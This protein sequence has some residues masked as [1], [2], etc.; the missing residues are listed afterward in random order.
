MKNQINVSKDIKRAV[1]I[2][3]PVV[4]EQRN[5]KPLI[6]RIFT[7]FSSTDIIFE[8]IIIDDHSTD[9]TSEVVNSLKKKYQ[10]RYFLKKGNKGKAYSLLEGFS[11]A[12]FNLLAMI[13]ADLQYPPEAIP[14]MV[15]KIN[16]EIGVVVAKRNHAKSNFTRKLLSFGFFY[17]FVK[18]LHGLD[19][20][21]QSGLKVFKKEII[22]RITLNPGPWSFDLEF[23]IKAKHAGYKI[24]DHNIFFDKRQ[25]EKPKISLIPAT[26]EIGLSALR[27]KF[28]EHEPI[29]FHPHDKK[30]KQEGFHYKGVPFVPH[31]NVS[32]HESALKTLHVNQKLVFLNLLLLVIVGL[33]YNWLVTS[34]VLIGVV[35]FI[36]FADL[37]FNLFLILRNFSK[38]PELNISNDEI[39]KLKNSDLPVYTILCPLYHEWEVLP[40]FVTA[41]SRLDYPK[42]KLQVMLLLEEDD[43]ETV[44]QAKSHKLP[45]YFKIVVV[46]HSLP[47]TKPKALNYGLT[48]AKGD[49]IVVYDAEDVPDPKQLKKV[50]AAF[51]KT[52]DKT[53]CIQA[54]L[55]FYNPHH[56]ILTR[57]FTA[58]YSLW[59]DLV[60][61]GLQSIFAPIPLGGTSNHFKI[62]D[63][64]KLK[65]WDSF[66]VTEDCD[67]G[68]RLVKHGYR[69]ALINS[70]TLEEANSD[71]RN[72]FQQRTRWIKG[73]LQTYLVHMRN[74]RD[75][76]RS[77]SKF[78]LFTFQLIV[79]GKILSMFINPLMWV[80]TIAYFAFRPIA[81]P[82]IQQFFPAPIL[83][84]GVFSLVF[85]NFL[86]MYYYMIGCVKRGH[87]D[88]V[89][90]V[91]LVPFYWLCM[92]IA[93]WKAVTQLIQN[94]HFWPKTIHG[95]HIDREKALLQSPEY[96]RKL[97]QKS[98][99]SF[100]VIKVNGLLHALFGR[101]NFAIRNITDF[102]DAFRFK[103]NVQVNQRPEKSIL[104]L[105]WRDTKHKF[106]GGAEVYIHEL[107]KRWV[108][109]G[110]KVTL[111][112]GNDGNCKRYEII[113]GVEIIRRG[114]F[115]FVYIWA[116]IYYLLKFRGKYNTIIDCENGIPF[117]TP[118]YVKERV[119][120]LMFHVHQEVFRQSLIKPLAVF[121]SLLENKFM[122]WVYRNIK[123]ITI[124]ESSKKEIENLGLG[125][126][127]IEIVYPGVNLEL[128]QPAKK[129]FIPTVAY[130]GRLKYYK[131]LHVFIH[132]VRQILQDFPQ[133]NIN[134]I[135]AGEGEEK[136]NLIKLAK[137]L[138][139]F[140]KI[141][142]LGKISEQEKIKLY[143]K[144]W[145]FVNP[146][147]MEG[148]GITTIEAN[149]CATP[150]VASNVPGLRDSVDNPHSGFL[151]A[152]GSVKEFSIQILKLIKDDS[153]RA[154]MSI[155]AMYWAQQF[156]W[157]KSADK[158][159]SI[160]TQ[161]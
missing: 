105:N 78:H 45:D 103:S 81:G 9:K 160:I 116:F 67:L 42:E 3:I 53:F 109:N 37:V 5:V 111:F 127:G 120:S 100:P 30:Y 142:F 22:E 117:F 158:S 92:S 137:K 47:K 128:F 121:A 23:L 8:L 16:S 85:G 36:Y 80:T 62:A 146:S 33:L 43:K 56:N 139:V 132:T 91:F 28:A 18:I 90:Y 126:S 89:K 129:S 104:V 69:T 25:D 150:V 40:Q 58:E 60:L 123:F 76:I 94:P 79:G 74:P 113:D 148:W 7:S 14:E 86:Y 118:L 66:N 112:C 84:M 125:K 155:E 106:A 107:A 10:I 83:Y 12:R 108:Q 145:V 68:M 73:Y 50:F 24:A 61:T 102:L 144:A 72:W 114:G 134:F 161:S 77:A 153:L 157:Q 140:N 11:H 1:S 48:K 65:G 32:L 87:Y 71:L 27:L 20:D 97:S 101:V 95:F 34:I 13:D 70:V 99:L 88:L 119:Y 35:T 6:E 93:A 39:L 110:Y 154:K 17:P 4:N 46:P 149:A 63:L 159:L 122:P 133:I 147:F 136:N 64:K 138:S 52:D 2:I 15:E 55:N 115:Y 19:H 21:V 141:T 29:P 75:F 49:Y 51:Q 31:S 135:I 130:I 156:D 57:I 26:A 98:T 41:M 44:R 152:Y 131:S 54:K 143:Q 82:F 124:S 96:V 59:F 38:K 151:V